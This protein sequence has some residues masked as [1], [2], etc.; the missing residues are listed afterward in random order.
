[1]N[2]IEISSRRLSRA[3]FLKR[4][5]RIDCTPS[6]EFAE[7]ITA[8]GLRKECDLRFGDF[9]KSSFD[10]N[11]LRGFDF[12]GCDL[13]GSSFVGA[14]IEG[15]KFD[16]ARVDIA[17]LRLAADYAA[18]SKTDLDRPPHERHR[19]RAARLRDL[20][21]FRE[22][23]FAP[24]M[25]VMPAGEF[26][27]GS[28]LGEAKLREDDQAFDFEI[29]RG[30]GKRRMRIPRRFAMGRFPVTFEEYDA[31]CEVTLA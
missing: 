9:S 12:T 24:E 23:P 5:E 6:D 1:M 2:D 22:A 21:I 17:A 8:A 25:V 26:D 4:I 20:A 27:M 28:D 11:N 31:F 16:C 29:V 14:L 13:T 15:A 3:E 18:Y 10:G 7:L 30:Q 19:V